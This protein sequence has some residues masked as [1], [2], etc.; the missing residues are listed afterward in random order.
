[1]PEQ[2]CIEPPDAIRAAYLMQQLVGRFRARLIQHRSGRWEIV[3][4]AGPEPTRVLNDLLAAVQHWVDDGDDNH[5]TISFRD[6][7]CAIGGVSTPLPEETLAA[8]P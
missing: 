6:R 8:H 5:A 2:I 7:V 1:M 3:V 4:Q